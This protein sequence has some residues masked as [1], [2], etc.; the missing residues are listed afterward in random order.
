MI[1]YG[2]L[3]HTLRLGQLTVRVKY[4]PGVTK[5]DKTFL[6]RY[7]NFISPRAYVGINDIISLKWKY[8]GPKGDMLDYLGTL[9]FYLLSYFI[10]SKDKGL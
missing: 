1:K 3:N 2:P 5:G 4:K 8:Y 10:P 9:I 7:A 6:L